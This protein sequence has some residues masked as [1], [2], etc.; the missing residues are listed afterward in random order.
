MLP[1]QLQ[2]YGLHLGGTVHTSSVW[3]WVCNTAEQVVLASPQMPNF[4]I[5]EQLFSVPIKRH[6]IIG[7][8]FL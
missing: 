5:L 2:H 7:G 8:R 4:L 1:R 3:I 6:R